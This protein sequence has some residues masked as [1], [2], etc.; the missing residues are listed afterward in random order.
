MHR[1][2]PQARGDGVANGA[3]PLR[4]PPSTGDRRRPLPEP[5]DGRRDGDVSSA[6]STPTWPISRSSSCSGRS[7]R[8]RTGT[9]GSIGRESC[10]ELGGDRTLHAALAR[11]DADGDLIPDNRDR[12]RMTPRGT[13]TDDAGCPVPGTRRRPAAA[14]RSD[15]AVCSTG[16]TLLK[17]EACDDAP[18][19]RTSKPFSTAARPP[20][21]RS[22]PV[23]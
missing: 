5:R 11:G 22:R 21:Y 4:R 1:R 14:H 20:T 2:R 6:R 12:C 16:L 17:N 13:P 9:R 23:R 3:T 10:D 8:S 7:T 18:E 15:F 19:P